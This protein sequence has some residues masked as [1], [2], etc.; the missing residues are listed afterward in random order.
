MADAAHVC[1]SSSDEPASIGQPT[2]PQLPSIPIATD[3]T[4]ALA[5]INALRNAFNLL[6]GIRPQYVVYPARQGVPGV[7]GAPGKQG[8]APK[9]AR[10]REL[11]R[12]TKVVRV[13]NPKD[14]TQYVDIRRIEQLIM[15]DRV[16][17]EQWVWNRSGGGNDNNET[18]PLNVTD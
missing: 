7:A 1:H 14:K 10:V 15:K 17:G 8:K 9:P 6:A 4:S 16:T 2:T 3:L 18:D 12:K 11:S 13:H 5:A